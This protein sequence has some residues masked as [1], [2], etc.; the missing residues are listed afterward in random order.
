MVLDF[1]PLLR[2]EPPRPV[3]LRLLDRLVK[4]SE[5][6][7]LRPIE[8]FRLFFTSVLFRALAATTNAYARV[9]DTRASG[10]RY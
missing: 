10:Y 5:Y 2:D 7:E 4:N 3:K 6:R 8:F 1:I 9:K